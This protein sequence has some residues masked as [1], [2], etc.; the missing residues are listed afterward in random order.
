MPMLLLGTF[1]ANHHDRIIRHVIVAA[2]AT[3]ALAL[4]LG[5]CLAKGYIG[6]PGAE[7]DADDRRV[8][9]RHRWFGVRQDPVPRGVAIAG[10][11]V[12]SFLALVRVAQL[13]EHEWAQAAFGLPIIVFLGLFLWTMPVKPK[14]RS[15]R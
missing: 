14:D 15:A 13:I 4:G 9:I 8:R 2:V 5:G 6:G 7:V 11:I 12:V 3:V 1:F 10:W